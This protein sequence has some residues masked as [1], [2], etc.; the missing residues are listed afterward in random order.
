MPWIASSRSLSSG[1]PAGPR[2]DPLAL[3]NG[4]DGTVVTRTPLPLRG[5]M[6]ILNHFPRH[7]DTCGQGPY[8]TQESAMA[9]QRMD[10]EIDI[11]RQEQ[12]ALRKHWLLWGFSA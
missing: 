2:P 3:G 12:V 4:D 6:K 8:P 5:L 1:R 9:S 11:L 10:T 7:G